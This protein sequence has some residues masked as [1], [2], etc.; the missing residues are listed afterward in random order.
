M[1]NKNLVHKAA[2]YRVVK[3]IE[4]VASQPTAMYG[5]EGFSGDE[6]VTLTALSENRRRIKALVATLNESELELCHL[7]EIVE[8]FL[9]DSYGINSIK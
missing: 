2:H 6:T 4:N 1:Q 7:R 9:F 3:T 5:I 8:N